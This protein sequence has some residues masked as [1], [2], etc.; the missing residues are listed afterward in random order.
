MIKSIPIPRGDIVGAAEGG[1]ERGERGAGEGGEGGGA[2]GVDLEFGV[3][4]ANG[5]GSNVG[6]S[7]SVSSPFGLSC[8][9]LAPTPKYLQLPSATTTHAIWKVWKTGTS[10]MGYDLWAV[11]WEEG[12][13]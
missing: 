10:E 4:G 8:S 2:G 9:C 11:A 5:G 12:G 7:Q 6:A 3:E 1:R 13:G